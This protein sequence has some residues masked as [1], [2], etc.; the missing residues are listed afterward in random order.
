MQ[1]EAPKAVPWRL[2]LL[3]S[4]GGALEFYDFLVFGV[5][6]P[7]IGAAFFPSSDPWLS[8]SMVFAGFAVGY[9][10]R[11]VGGL[12]LSHFGDRFGRR[13]VF[14][15]SVFV[16]SASTLA[17][18]LLPG[19]A[20][21]GIT[22]PLLLLALRLVQGF[23]FGGELPGAITY[24]VETV[25]DRASFVCGVL[26]AT[27]NSGV[28]LAALVNLVVQETLPATVLPDLG[29][30]IGFLF[31]GALGLL[32]FLLRRAMVETPAF[33][34]MREH[35]A[36]V[37]LREV[38]ARQ[39]WSVVIGIAVVAVSAGFNGLLFAFMPGYLRGLHYDPVVAAWAHNVGI[40]ALT[41]GVLCS[42]W[43]G[44]RV[45]RRALLAGGSALLLL[46][47]WPF[48][49]A[50]ATHS[51]PLVPLIVVAGLVAG[52]PG[53]AWGAMLAEMFATRVRFSGVA[54][55]ANVS[56]AVFGGTTPLIATTLIKAT[57]DGAAPAA[58][59]AVTA[60]LALLGCLF[61][62]RH[63]GRLGS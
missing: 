43:L 15:G 37:P 10:A 33:Q 62:A 18:G 42:A 21:W 36:R 35:V 20:S 16:V 31:G 25:P 59:M 9:F 58:V 30:R 28:L 54:L 29:W 56:F 13:R 40:V 39:P 49:H 57:G 27:I 55:S 34:R 41:S 50:V 63:A 23:C 53:G 12:V 22:A 7:S 52:L 61:V 51:L 32:G 46:G 4:L 60:A 26:F 14:I 19:Y 5:F 44:D 48:F 47:C 38:L 6:A 8:Q 2:I 1:R 17:M 3:A 45:S 24:L 11:P